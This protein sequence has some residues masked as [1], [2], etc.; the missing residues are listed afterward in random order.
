MVMNTRL[1][2]SA[3]RTMDAGGFSTKNITTSETGSFQVGI[4]VMN[5]V[6]FFI[7]VL[8]GVNDYSCCFILLLH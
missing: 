6:R 3:K 2:L 5:R 8:P 7:M 1:I 4:N